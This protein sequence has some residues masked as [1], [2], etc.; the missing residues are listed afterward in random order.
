MLSILLDQ[1][2][3]SM[4]RDIWTPLSI[5]KSKLEERSISRA[6]VTSSK[7]I[8]SPTNLT[9]TK[10]ITPRESSKN[11]SKERFQ[12][13]MKNYLSW[14]RKKILYNDLESQKIKFNLSPL[15][16]RWVKL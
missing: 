3:Q 8:N 13:D 15:E 12:I 10:E 5:R 14:T 6:G 9:S 16:I 11:V 2:K 7:W 4:L 1:N